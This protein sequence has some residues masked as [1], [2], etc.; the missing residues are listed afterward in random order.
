MRNGFSSASSANTLTQRQNGYFTAFRVSDAHTKNTLRVSP[1]PERA[2]THF[3]FFRDSN[4]S[5]N[6]S[7]VCT[8]LHRSS[9][10]C[11]H[12]FVFCSSE[13]ECNST[14]KRQWHCRN[15]MTLLL[16]YPPHIH[17]YNFTTQFAAR[18]ARQHIPLFH[19]AED[20][21]RRRCH[22]TWMRR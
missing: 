7:L 10:T 8:A 14:E 3:T 15:T 4:A 1:F 6:K 18:N 2:R 22:V 11:F 21:H 13:L 17:M 19:E 12:S 16:S 5:F 9:L 20:E